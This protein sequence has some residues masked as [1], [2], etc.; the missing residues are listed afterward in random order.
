[1]ANPEGLGHCVY[2]YIVDV[3]KKQNCIT[4]A[5]FQT[6]KNKSHFPGLFYY[7]CIYGKQKK[8]YMKKHIESG[9]N[10]KESWK[11]LSIYTNWNDLKVHPSRGKWIWNISK[12]C[13]ILKGIRGGGVSICMCLG[14]SLGKWGGLNESGDK[15]KER[16]PGRAFA[17]GCVWPANFGPP[18]S[19]WVGT[20][21]LSD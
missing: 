17:A 2:E 6:P 16:R 14:E 7:T 12:Y 10:T 11:W 13:T 15:A 5:N 1:M 18:P 3:V 9:V 21:Q 19:T 20:F 4:Q 8:Q